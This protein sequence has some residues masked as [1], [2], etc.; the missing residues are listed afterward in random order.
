[1]L[2][3]YLILQMVFVDGEYIG[4]V[5]A[6]YAFYDIE[7]CEDNKL[8]FAVNHLPKEENI[9]H[10]YSCVEYNPQVN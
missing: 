2:T 6:P 5:P 10:S 7:A 8:S 3:V 4:S 9:K 1:M